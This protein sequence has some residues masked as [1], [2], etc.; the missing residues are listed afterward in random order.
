MISIV[1]HIPV[2]YNRIY[3]GYSANDRWLC[4]GEHWLGSN[5]NF[6]KAID[7]LLHQSSV[8]IASISTD[9]ASTL[10][11]TH[12]FHFVITTTKRLRVHINNH[13]TVTRAHAT[14]II[15][16]LMIYIIYYCSN[17]CQCSPINDILWGGL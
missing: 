1:G 3:P 4:E 17:N 13:E 2:G 8:I 10:T 9:Q 5:N 14:A 16:G 6:F 15:S 12:H 7:R 11:H